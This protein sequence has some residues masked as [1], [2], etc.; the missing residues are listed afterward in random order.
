MRIT[1]RVGVSVQARRG[2]V[3]EHDRRRIRARAFVAKVDAH[4]VELEELGRRRRPAR[5]ERLD[6]TV[7]RPGRRDAG[8][9][10]EQ[11]EREDDSEGLQQATHCAHHTAERAGV[12]LA[13]ALE[14]TDEETSC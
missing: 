13:P 7:R 9:Q 8:H 1:R 2:S 12:T 6:R 5:E 11:D 3:N 14:S 4:A 10:Q